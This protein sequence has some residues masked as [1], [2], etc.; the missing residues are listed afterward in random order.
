MPIIQPPPAPP[1]KETIAIRL[2][3][4]IL[5][6]LRRYAACVPTRN[7]SHIIAGAL[8]R[9]FNDDGDYKTWRDSHPELL[10][11]TKSR[12]DGGATSKH[13]TSRSNPPSTGNSAP[14][15]RQVESRNSVGGA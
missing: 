15:D 5:E 8:Q 2:D 11:T 6:E 9:L 10:A 13:K 14:S 1:K 4:Q 12:R 3:A 7:L